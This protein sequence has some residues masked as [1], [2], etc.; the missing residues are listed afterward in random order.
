M[1]K[2][3]VTFFTLYFW[4]FVENHWPYNVMRLQKVPLIIHFKGSSHLT[5]KEA[6]NPETDPRIDGKKFN[7]DVPK[8]I[9]KIFKEGII[10][11]CCYGN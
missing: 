6:L 2:V 9:P 1:E 5:K 7:K 11:C 8:T 3:K 4:F 10:F